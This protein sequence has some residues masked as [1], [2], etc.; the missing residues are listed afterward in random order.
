MRKIAFLGLCFVAG[1]ASATA[2]TAIESASGI[3]VRTEQYPRPPYSEAN[4]FIYEKA[5]TTVCTKLEVCNKYDECQSSYHRGSYKAATDQKTGEPYGTTPAVP[6][7]PGTLGKHVCL[8]RYKLI[9][10]R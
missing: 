5:G 2:V 4:Y 10:A 1:L 9:G 7:A 8:A 6:I 3:T